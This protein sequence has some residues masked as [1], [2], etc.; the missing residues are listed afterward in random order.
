M[1]TAL[2]G[3]NIQISVLYPN[4][5]ALPWV[6]IFLLPPC[7]G[8]KFSY[9]SSALGLNLSFCNGPVWYLMVP[10]TPVWSRMVLYGPL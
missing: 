8:S 2:K 10:Y 1:K 3:L 5:F 7:P 9:F 6:G 4:T